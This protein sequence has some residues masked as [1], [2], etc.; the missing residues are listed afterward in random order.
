[1]VLLSL[2][3]VY[4]LIRGMTSFCEPSPRVFHGAATINNEYIVIFGGKN[5]KKNSSSFY[6][7]RP[8]EIKPTLD[9][10]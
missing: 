7:L 6:I 10:E 3:R 4:P 5:V 1:M 2:S 9:I 8:K